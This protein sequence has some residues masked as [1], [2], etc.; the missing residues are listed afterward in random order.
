MSSFF[1]PLA[2]IMMAATESGGMNIMNPRRPATNAGM[3]FLSEG[4][5]LNALR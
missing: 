3:A 4:A 5:P 1:L 2:D